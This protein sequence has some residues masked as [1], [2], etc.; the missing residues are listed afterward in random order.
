MQWHKTTGLLIAAAAFGGLCSVATGDTPDPVFWTY[1]YLDG[2]AVGHAHIIRMVRSGTLDWQTYEYR[3]PGE[4]ALEVAARITGDE[5]GWDAYDEGEVCILLQSI[6]EGDG[7]PSSNDVE[8]TALF[9]HWC[10]SLPD[11]DNPFIDEEGECLYTPSRPQHIC[12]R[13]W[14]THWMSGGDDETSEWMDTFCEDLKDELDSSEAPYP[15]R[16]HFDSESPLLWD[17][18]G[19][20][21]AFRD[22]FYACTQDDRWDG[23]YLGNSGYVYGFDALYEDTHLDDLWGDADSAGFGYVTGWDPGEDWDDEDN[24]PWVNWYHSTY[25]QAMDGAMEAACYDAIYD[26][27]GT[28]VFCSNFKTSCRISSDYNYLPAGAWGAEDWSN[29]HWQGSGDLQAPVL[30]GV[31]TAY[32][33]QACSAGTS[34]HWEATIGVHRHNIDALIDTLLDESVSADVT[35]ITPWIM[36]VG[37]THRGITMTQDR[38]REL[39]AMLRVRKLCEFILLCYNMDPQ[40][41]W[42]PQVDAT[43]QAWMYDLDSCSIVTGT[44]VSLQPCSN[45]EFASDRLS[46]DVDSASVF[47]LALATVE[48]TFDDNPDYGIGDDPPAEAD[49]HVMIEAV[50]DEGSDFD[51]VT[52]DVEIYDNDAPGWELI[53]DG[54]TL[55]KTAA[56]FYLFADEDDG[57]YINGN[58][59]VLIRVKAYGTTYIGDEFTLSID[60]VSIAGGEH[61]E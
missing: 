18:T 47:P 10:D 44:P 60:S 35:E 29:L 5:S 27:L 45:L 26:E 16:F 21:N 22:A 50:L 25:H 4:V 31:D 46:F 43:D 11:D 15:S 24:Q 14:L 8:A 41:D 55:G 52:F 12:D 34:G 20:G 30:Y 57:D 19:A 40:E 54:A 13:W 2:S 23:S 59:E 39:L 32:C 42:G 28:N 51:E 37:L 38:M 1:T 56:V 53:L 33:E 61:E 36:A 49:V 6:G 9:S 48:I 17:D 7:N 58:D 3:S